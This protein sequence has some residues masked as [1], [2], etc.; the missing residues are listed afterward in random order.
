M[1]NQIRPLP[2]D[3]AALL[4]VERR[5]SSPPPSEIDRLLAGIQAR[6]GSMPAP[7]AS[8][9]AGGVPPTPAAAPTTAIVAAKPII[10]AVAV[11]S[12]LGA[13]AGIRWSRNRDAAGVTAGDG[14]GRAVPAS[15]PTAQPG[16]TAAVYASPSAASSASPSA[17]PSALDR[18]SGG[19]GAPTPGLQKGGDLG[20]ES[21]LLDEAFRALA[22]ND[23]ASALR[24]LAE[25]RR[26]FAAGA[27]AEEREALEVK[28]LAR[29]GDLDGARR[30]A[31]RF[32]RQFPHSVQLQSIMGAV[33]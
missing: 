30:Q 10:V 3:V 23:A 11:L 26:A 18:E 5:A 31:H 2:D 27:L 28:V 19:S 29:A 7:T 32:Q 4:E 13:A 1:R 16:A 15:A 22:A 14:F 8:S 20:A 17:S 25:H 24:S 21:A 12:A 33:R 6:L 9:P